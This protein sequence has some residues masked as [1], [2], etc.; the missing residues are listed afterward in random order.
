YMDDI[1]VLPLSQWRRRGAK[2][3]YTFDKFP[4]KQ[5]KL[6]KE[7]AFDNILKRKEESA[8]LRK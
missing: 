3:S 6:F 1:Y 8:L 5:L 4:P 2:E 7:I